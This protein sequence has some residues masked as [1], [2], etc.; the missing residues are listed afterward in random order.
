MCKILAK[1]EEV[2]FRDMLTWRG[3]TLVSFSKNWKILSLIS[4]FGKIV[5]KIVFEIFSSYTLLTFTMWQFKM[6][7]YI[8]DLFDSSCMTNCLKN[9]FLWSIRSNLITSVVC[10]HKV[11]SEQWRWNM[12]QLYRINTITLFKDIL[13]KMIR[14]RVGITDKCFQILV[15]LNHPRIYAYIR[16]ISK[17]T[18][19]CEV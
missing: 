17:R 16:K 2:G 5:I 14:Q 8:P 6:L 13:V 4:N 15:C 1:S 10:R 7:I 18:A 19:W 12:P 11:L 3:M 9:S